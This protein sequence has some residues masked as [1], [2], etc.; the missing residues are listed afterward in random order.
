MAMLLQRI[1]TF[2]EEAGLKLN[3]PKCCLMI[4]DRRNVIPRPL[5]HIPDIQLKDE[6]IYLGVSISNVGG[7]ENEIKRRFGMAKSALASL[8]KIWKDHHISKETKKR[9]VQTLI[10]PIATYGSESWIVN[11][12]CRRRIEA[13]E[14]TCYRRMLR[15]PWTARRTNASILQELNINSN[16]R[17]LPSIQQQILKFFGHIIRRDGFEKLMIQGKVDGKRQRGRSPN[18]YLDQIKTLAN[19][20]LEH[21]M[22]SVE[23][24][25][26]WRN[27]TT[28]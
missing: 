9:L 25:E 1:K 21:I 27:I 12:A 22:H 5:Q 18:R 3:V 8:T 7:C 15:I 6:V 13:F 10:F 17:L 14:M 23:D 4:V 11:A 26:T 28:N 24:R 19:L 16:T 2:S 20:P